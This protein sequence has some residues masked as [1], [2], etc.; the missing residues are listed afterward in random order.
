MNGRLSAL[1]GVGAA[2]LSAPAASAIT[3]FRTP[4]RTIYCGVVEAHESPEWFVPPL[5]CW[6]PR[7]GFTVFLRARHAGRG[8]WNP[9]NRGADLFARDVLGHD[10][11]YWAT[12]SQSG[13]GYRARERVAY[14]CFNRRTGLTCTNRLGHGFWLGT[15]SGV[16]FFDGRGGS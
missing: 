16:H 11:W 1:A 3:E 14:R 6:R 4:E 8:E 2:L 10:D 5:T 15:R 9:R 12:R 7:N 13:L